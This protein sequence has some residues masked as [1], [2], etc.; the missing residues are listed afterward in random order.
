MRRRA[1]PAR[2]CARVMPAAASTTPIRSIST[3]GREAVGLSLK[4]SISTTA[5]TAL[6]LAKYFG[7]SACQSS[8]CA[9][10]GAAPSHP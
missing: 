3:S 8:Q 7:K 5:D 1:W 9:N 10:T 4:L 6:R 2:T